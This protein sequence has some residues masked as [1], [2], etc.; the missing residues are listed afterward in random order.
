MNLCPHRANDLVKGF[1]PP[2]PVSQRG[3]HS[4]RSNTS[5]N[6]QPGR[7]ACWAYEEDEEGDADADVDAGKEFLGHGRRLLPIGGHHQMHARNSGK[8]PAKNALAATGSNRGNSKKHSK[9]PQEIDQARDLSI[10]AK[11]KRQKFYTQRSW[12]AKIKTLKNLRT[13]TNIGKIIRTP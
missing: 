2:D 8:F 11:K 6:W 1:I 10:N 13:L 5:H 4:H 9:Y 7:T 12:A 3:P